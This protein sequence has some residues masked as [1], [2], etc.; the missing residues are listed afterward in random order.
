MD[1]H[2]TTIKAVSFYL[3]QCFNINKCRKFSCGTVVC[4]HFASYQYYPNYKCD[5]N[6]GLIMSCIYVAP[7]KARNFNVVYMDLHLATL[8][9]VSLSICCTMFQHWINAES[10]SLSQCC[11]NTLPATKVSLITNVIYFGSLRFKTQIP[12]CLPQGI[13]SFIYSFYIWP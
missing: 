1:L 7:S 13:H 11:V 6:L 12:L 3:L 5:L 4:K 2:L 10:F 9:A 8:K